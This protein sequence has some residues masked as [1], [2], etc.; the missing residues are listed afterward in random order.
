MKAVERG[1]SLVEVLVALMLGVLISGAAFQLFAANQRTFAL[2]NALSSLHEDGQMVLRYMMADARNAGRGSALLGA[3][4]GVI[5]DASAAVRSV[6]GGDGGNDSVV[7]NYFGITDCQGTTVAAEV[8]IINRYFVGNDGVLSCSGNLSAGEV[9]L[10]PNVESFQVQYGIDTSPGDGV[11]ATQYVGANA[12]TAAN[13]VVAIRFALLLSSG[14]VSIG[15][16]S[17]AESYYVLDQ[18]VDTDDDQ[19][20]RRVFMST[21]QLRNYNWDDV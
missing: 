20:I 17:S 5:F 7:L 18:K 6:D 14:E 12:L 1:Y 4:P 16:D 21:V 10:L 13:P 3:I 8:E 11:G 2:Q 9:E 15:T 19:K